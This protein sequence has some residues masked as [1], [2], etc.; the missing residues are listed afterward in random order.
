MGSVSQVCVASQAPEFALPVRG[1]PSPLNQT[2]FIDA[3]FRYNKIPIGSRFHVAHDTS[4]SRN[5]PALEFRRLD[6]ESH[7]H[8][9]LDG[10]FDIA[11]GTIQIR[12]AVG[13]RPWPAWR[14]PIG[15]LA[16]VRIQT[17]E[18][19]PRVVGVP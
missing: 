16:I 7:Q 12:D 13:L 19:T 14:W 4:A 5:R 6:V 9:G 2:N 10:G 1:F 18:I 11:D 17:A 8:I 15:Y 3:A